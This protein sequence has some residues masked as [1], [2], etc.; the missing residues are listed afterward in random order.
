MCPLRAQ[1]VVGIGLNVSNEEP[2]TCIDALLREE[3]GRHGSEPASSPA[4]SPEVSLCHWK[5]L[6]RR[7]GKAKPLHVAKTQ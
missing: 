4:V 7:H 2:S 6:V 1:V 3:H 5:S